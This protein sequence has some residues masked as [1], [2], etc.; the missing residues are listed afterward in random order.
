MATKSQ[1][2]KFIMDTFTEADGNPVSKSKLESYKKA[3]LE[4]FIKDRNA[5]A[6]LAEW[7]ENN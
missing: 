5:E 1:L 2:I 6:D 7:L 3:D 4:K